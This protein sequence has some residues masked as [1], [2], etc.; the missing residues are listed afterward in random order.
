LEEK[1]CQGSWSI[2]CIIKWETVRGSWSPP[3]P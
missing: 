3:W 2:S 1:G